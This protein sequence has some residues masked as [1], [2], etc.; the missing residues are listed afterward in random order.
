MSAIQKAGLLPALQAFGAALGEITNDDVPSAYEMVVKLEKMLEEARDLLKTRALL[1][2]NVNGVKVTDGGTKAA[3]LGGFVMRAVPMRTG[4]DP[5]KLEKAVRA[6]RLDPGS[7]MDATVTYKVNQA[8]L[9]AL[10]ERG[11]ITEE[12]LKACAYDPS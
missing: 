11:D 4:V 12:D 9:N 10:V 5:K 6:K 8:K 1:Y 7:C 2:L 3:N